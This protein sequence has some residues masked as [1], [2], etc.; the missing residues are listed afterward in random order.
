MTPVEKYA[1][2]MAITSA[3]RER[4]RVGFNE[5]WQNWFRKQVAGDSDYY[6]R[7]LLSP[8]KTTIAHVPKE[9]VEIKRSIR[10][11]K[12]LCQTK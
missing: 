6:L 9:L 5:W 7:R 11:L 4:Q 1:R 10:T 8:G 12:K 2:Q 3:S